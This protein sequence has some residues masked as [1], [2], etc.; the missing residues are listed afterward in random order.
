MKLAPLFTPM[1]KSPRILVPSL[2]L[3]HC[4]WHKTSTSWFKKAAQTLAIMSA[5]RPAEGGIAKKNMPLPFKG[6]PESSSGHISSYTVVQVQHVGTP[7][8]EIR[9]AV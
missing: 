7:G 4:P 3:P 5:F 2:L 6:F 9:A 1:Y 8:W